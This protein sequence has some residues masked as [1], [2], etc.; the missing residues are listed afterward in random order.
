MT[1]DIVRRVDEHKTKFNKGFT[2]KYN[3]NILVYYEKLDSPGEAIRR[4]KQLKRWNRKWKLAL[5]E[6]YNPQWKD[7]YYGL[8]ESDSEFPDLIRDQG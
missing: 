2:S 6:K 1:N 4:E 3:V 5:I 7:L 8:I